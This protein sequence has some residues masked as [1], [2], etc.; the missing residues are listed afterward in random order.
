[1]A[2]VLVYL[3]IGCVYAYGMALWHWKAYKRHDDHSFVADLW[4]LAPA[5]VIG[6]AVLMFDKDMREM[7]FAGLG[8]D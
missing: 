1:M 3:G 2:F 4:W 8:E 7:C 5:D 6:W